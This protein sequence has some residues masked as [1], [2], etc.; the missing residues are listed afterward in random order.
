MSTRSLKLETLADLIERDGADPK[1]TMLRVL[2]DFYL[3]K[4]LHTPEED[5]HFT[6]LAL[7]LIGDV[8]STTRA[9]IARRLTEHGGAP[10]IVLR[11]LTEANITDS[12]TFRFAPP[13][14][15]TV[16]P[17]PPPIQTAAI[18]APA[19]APAM[20]ERPAVRTTDRAAATD[21]SD[22]F[23]ASDS[24]G[25][26]AMLRELEG[27]AVKLPAIAA[28]EAAATCRELEGAALRS[29][30][31][32]FVRE[33][34]RALDVPRTVAQKIV[35]DSSGE[36]MLVIARALG[37][38]IDAVQRILLLVNPAVGTSVRRVFD[39]TEL[40]HGMSEQSALRLVAL[41]RY[42]AEP[43]GQGSAP[44]RETAGT[45]RMTADAPRPQASPAHGEPVKRDQRAS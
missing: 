3:Q 21:F 34:E 6:E 37:M 30:P 23:F 19:L 36:P 27:G 5:R 1:P 12:D 8:D 25:R 16:A 15:A 32:E 18:P 9:D 10:A 7:R 29:R 41:W 17:P 2:T 20:P 13:A 43:D 11:R 28:H 22:R 44:Q 42:A 38:P 40:Y 14:H 24:A 4:A 26:R 39:L 45:R 33:M 31:F 35:N